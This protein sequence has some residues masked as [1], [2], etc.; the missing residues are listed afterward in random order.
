MAKMIDEEVTTAWY[1]ELQ[2]L[3]A[4]ANQQFEKIE[5]YGEKIR[6]GVQT[7]QA[8]GI[9]RKRLLARLKTLWKKHADAKQEEKDTEKPKKGKKRETAK[10]R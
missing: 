7:D 1:L 9:N 4:D 6:K 5:M 10:R 2:G 3:E 8:M